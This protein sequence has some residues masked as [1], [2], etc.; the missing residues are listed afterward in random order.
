M[1]HAEPARVL[2]VERA[3]LAEDPLDAGVVVARVVAEVHVAGALL[4]VVAEAGQRPRLLADVRLAVP[5]AGAE[6]EELHHL[7]RVVLVRRPLRVVAAVQPEEHRRV[8]RHVEQQLLE[9]A[10]PVVAEEL[11]L[12][13][14]QPLRVDAAVRGR[15]PV[16]PD[17]RHPLDERARRAHHPVEPPDVVVAPRVVG[18]ERSSLL[19]LRRGAD[20][21][22]GAGM[23][24]RL[25]TA[26]SSPSAASASAS[27]FRGPKPARQSSRSACATPNAPVWAATP[28]TSRHVCCRLCRPHP[29]E[30]GDLRCKGMRHRPTSAGRCRSDRVVKRPRRRSR[31]AGPCRLRGARTRPSHPRGAT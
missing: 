20:E 17:E 4:P 23:G 11:V 15:E 31:P 26:P 6:R 22:L 13:Q 25:E 3:A 2:P 5:A 29:P 9:R 24:Q 19:V 28:D 7:A 21:P 12:I 10:E 30:A 14:H 1:R 16:V 8:L 27:P 18:R